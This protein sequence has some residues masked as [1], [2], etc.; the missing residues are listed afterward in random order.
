MW[1]TK[2]FPGSATRHVI[3]SPLVSWL[4]ASVLEMDGSIPL[5][6]G[7]V[8]K[9]SLKERKYSRDHPKPAQTNSLIGMSG[10]LWTM[11][12]NHWA[13]KLGKLEIRTLL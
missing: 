12:V 8:N 5:K 7:P 10:E 2:E 11:F 3:A 4:S 6:V 1:F 9:E 13:A